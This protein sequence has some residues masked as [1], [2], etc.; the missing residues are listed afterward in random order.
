MYKIHE[1]EYIVII[2]FIQAG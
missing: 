2:S 1:K